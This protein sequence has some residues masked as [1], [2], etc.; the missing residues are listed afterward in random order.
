MSTAPTAEAM[1]LTLSK[2]I[3]DL[4]IKPFRVPSLTTN[5]DDVS[6]GALW[7][8]SDQ[9]KIFLNDGTTTMEL[10][11]TSDPQS[12]ISGGSISDR[13]IANTKLI[14]NS[15]TASELA[16]NSVDTAELVNASV[17]GAK[18]NGAIT[19]V[20][21]IGITAD[22]P[23]V[24][25]LSVAVPSNQTASVAEF[26]DAAAVRQ[27]M[28]GAD[29]RIRFGSTPTNPGFITV[30]NNKTGSDP[31]I[32]V[33]QGSAQTGRALEVRN[34][35]GTLLAYVDFAGASSFTTATA[36]HLVAT[37]DSSLA[38]AT[39][40]TLAVGG[41]S[42]LTG[43]V[44]MPAGAALGQLSIGSQQ[45]ASYTAALPT[46]VNNCIVLGAITV[47]GGG[48]LLE[49]NCAP[50]STTAGPS[51]RYVIPATYNATANVWQS[52]S[53][54]WT[55]GAVGT[56][57]YALEVNIANNVVNL[58][59]RN[60]LGSATYNV[61]VSIST[62]A[63]TTGYSWVPTGSLVGAQSIPAAL[64]APSQVAG[65]VIAAHSL[66]GTQL[67]F[68]TVT[69]GTGAGVGNIAAATIN[70]Y[71][72]ANGAITS[73]KLTA[74]AALAAIASDGGIPDSLVN[75]LGASKIIA[76]TINVD[77]IFFGTS[78]HLYLGP[79]NH[80]GT[81]GQRIELNSNGI[82]IYN[83]SNAILGSLTPGGFTLSSSTSG[84]RLVL[85]TSGLV[86]Y[87]AD[88]VTKNLWL[89]DATGNATFAGALQAATGTFGGTLS[90]GSL[91]I[92]STGA[93]S[94]VTIDN[95][96]GVQV[97]W[98]GVMTASIPLTG[99]PVLNGLTIQ[100]NS[101]FAGT[102]TSSAT[103]TGGTLTGGT[104]T[105]GSLA[106]PDAVSSG[107]LQIDGTNG[108][109]VYAGGV[110]TAQ[111]PLSGS[112]MLQGVSVSGNSTF[113]GSI[114]STATIT[115]GTVIGDLRTGASGAYA[116]LVQS[117]GSGI[118]QFFSGDVDETMP[119]MIYS[120]TV[121]TGANKQI[122]M[123]V[124]S[125]ELNSGANSYL[126]LTS[127]PD[128]PATAT[129]ISGAYLRSPGEVIVTGSFGAVSNTPQLT[130]TT[131]HSGTAT[132]ILTADTTISTTGQLTLSN[133]NFVLTKG[134]VAAST[135]V[136]VET[137]A[138]NTHQLFLVTPFGGTSC[139][140]GPTSGYAPINASAFT[141][142]SAATHKRDISED[143][144]IVGALDAIKKLRPITYR[145]KVYARQTFP[146]H[147]NRWHNYGTH[148]SFMAAEV[149]EVLPEAVVPHHETGE[150][151][152][153]SLMT[154]V[155]TLTAA[156]KELAAEVDVLRA[157]RA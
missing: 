132:A 85:D 136:F 8:R 142:N 101:T 123:V 36:T 7:V 39:A 114:T 134:S 131:P 64:Y 15:I 143:D 78:G 107:R 81:T 144:N 68:D 139:V 59:L 65:S 135:L 14:L 58:R 54:S 89:D 117:G 111:L 67:A 77:D 100:G 104:I 60:T 137:A 82:Y 109:R 122:Q 157:A 5:P 31:S 150:P 95:T 98:G 18:L 70:G 29:G 74:G 79:T 103:I 25:P 19:Y 72:I 6:A 93:S 35:S 38:A 125:G 27:L 102:I 57:D 148:R 126:F 40:S 151:E 45:F 86:F 34:S 110:L 147:H 11:S 152:G 24:V 97:W 3:K 48:G 9:H 116:E 50:D 99:T 53:P 133:V 37:T 75:S 145:N 106:I 96:N 4:Q 44:N 120:Q 105:G 80:A 154:I 94:R 41:V 62:T 127:A 83:S 124:A 112:P 20:G 52:L 91:A 47:A 32:S 115:G 33:T 130:L 16:S 26:Y 76:G 73:G 13:S 84:A 153:L 46:V 138:A 22:Q 2:Q 155:S 128:N 156:V 113:A 121:G 17:T 108:I 118:V 66:T 87:A 10:Y 43:F 129:T 30:V 88:G 49:I 51:K 141:V 61:N 92:P 119:T 149:A 63:S 71:N 1:I 12:G 140:I 42:T 69:G 146:D 90:G 23:S 56:N 21:H 28:L 55:S